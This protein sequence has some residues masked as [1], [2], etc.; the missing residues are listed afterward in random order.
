MQDFLA[1]RVMGWGF[2]GEKAATAQFN[3]F[4]CLFDQSFFWFPVVFQKILVN[5]QDE[6]GRISWGAIQISSFGF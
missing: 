4:P 1:Y 5:V 3:V 6:S 2:V